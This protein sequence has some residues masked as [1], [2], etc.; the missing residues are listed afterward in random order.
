MAIGRIIGWVLVVLAVAA[1]GHEGFGW[2]QSGSYRMFALGELWAA[3]D[4]ASL[5]LFQAAIQRHVSPWL[6]E[7]VILRILLAPAWLVLIVPGAALAY[8]FRAGSYRRSS[9]LR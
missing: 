2:L 7:A 6:W 3:I 1:A 4:R 9:R 8:F 5:S